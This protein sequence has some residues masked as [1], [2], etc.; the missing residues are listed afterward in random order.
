MQERSAN[1]EAINHFRQ[2]LALVETLDPSE[3]REGL[4]FKFQIPLGVALLTAK[5]Y[6]PREVGP[7]FERARELGQKLAGPVEQFFVHWGIWAW[8]VV[9]E[10]LRLCHQ[11]AA[12]VLSIVEPLGDA[13]TPGG[14]LVHSRPDVAL[15]G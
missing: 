13:G 15:P 10:E 1:S 8:R 5:G 7:V 9:R 2:G 3:E 12:E 14:G 6:E 11:M 4:E